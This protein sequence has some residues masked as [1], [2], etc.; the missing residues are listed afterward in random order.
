MQGFTLAKLVLYQSATPLQPKVKDFCKSLPDCFSTL[1]VCVHLG[2]YVI[3]L[4]ESAHVTMNM[5]VYTQIVI[6][7]NNNF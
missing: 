6:E 5:Y 2:E 3:L 7:Y 4:K 1:Q